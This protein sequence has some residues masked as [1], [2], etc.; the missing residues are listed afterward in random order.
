MVKILC[1]NLG[2]KLGKEFLEK[3]TFHKLLPKFLRCVTHISEDFLGRKNIEA[4][5][6]RHFVFLYDLDIMNELFSNIA[7]N[8]NGYLRFQLRLFIQTY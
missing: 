3:E 4:K 2:A 1:E 7:R 6:K 5:Q 8:V